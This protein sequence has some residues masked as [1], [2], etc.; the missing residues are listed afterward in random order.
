MYYFQL[1]C[2]DV[3]PALYLFQQQWNVFVCA[4]YVAS[5]HLLT[6]SKTSQSQLVF[7]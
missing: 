2:D 7:F 3:T 6:L 5:C 4:N 1:A